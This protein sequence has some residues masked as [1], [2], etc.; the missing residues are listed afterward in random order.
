VSAARTA[1]VAVTTTMVRRMTPPPRVAVR[2]HAYVLFSRGLALVPTSTAVTLSL[3]EPLTAAA[4]G[5]VVLGERPSATGLLGAGLVLS[6]LAVL[7][8]AARTSSPAGSAGPGPGG[9]SG[10]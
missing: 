4:L 10:R 6:G 7:A 2:P 9:T 8:V 5:I 1:T 3:A